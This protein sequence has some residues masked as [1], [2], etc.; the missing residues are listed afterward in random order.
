MVIVFCVFLRPHRAQDVILRR[1]KFAEVAR[2]LEND[3]IHVVYT[4][5]NRNKKLSLGFRGLVLRLS[6]G[7]KRTK[8]QDTCIQTKDLFEGR[9]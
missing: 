8:T 3:L 2:A 6:S 7:Q 4:E 1:K 9:Q 5:D